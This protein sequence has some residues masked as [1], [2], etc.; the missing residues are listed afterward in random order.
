MPKQV[1]QINS[2]AVGHWALPNILLIVLPSLS[3]M[4]IG[5]TFRGC[6][7]IGIFEG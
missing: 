7:E 1:G 3:Y 2:W 4:R 6:D 5:D